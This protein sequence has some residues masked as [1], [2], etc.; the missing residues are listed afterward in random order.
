[1][2]SPAYSRWTCTATVVIAVSTIAYTYYAN[3]QWTVMSNTLTEIQKQTPEVQRQAKAAQDQ[4][5]LTNRPWI[6][7]LSAAPVGNKPPVTSIHF[8]EVNITGADPAKFGIGFEYDLQ[9]KNVGQSPALNA[10]YFGEVYVAPR[11][12]YGNF[13]IEEKRFC[14]LANSYHKSVEHGG[15]AIFPGDPYTGGGGGVSGA[16]TKEAIIVNPDGGPKGQYVM[17]VLI[18]C[19]D[20][21]FQSSNQHHQTRFAYEIFHTPNVGGSPYFLIG[22]GVIANEIFLARSEPDDYA[23]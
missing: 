16:I 13:A 8:A 12:K 18:G 11:G 17:P 9:G 1:M 3:R 15:T 10:R 22:K 2:L 7:I 23:N 21:Q 20:Y 6:K 14:E 4:L 5:E 19:V